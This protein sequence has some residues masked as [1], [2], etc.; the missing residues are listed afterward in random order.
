[1]KSGATS[2]LALIRLLDDYR[3]YH[4]ML[5]VVGGFFLLILLVLILV[6]RRK[7]K[8][9]SRQENR[10]WTFQRKM[11]FSFGVLSVVV[12]LLL[13]VIVAANVGTVLRPRPGFVGTIEMLG[14]PSAGTQRAKL[15]EAF[16]R[17]L[18]SGRATMPPAIRAAIDDR[19]A[20][21]RPKAIIS[22]ILLAL[23]AV[24]SSCIWRTLLRRSLVGRA[25]PMEKSRALRLGGVTSVAL[26]LVLML[27]VMGNTQGAIAPLCDDT[28]LR[29]AV[30]PVYTGVR[31]IF[32]TVKIT[33]WA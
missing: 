19:L 3:E 24:L 14:T 27:M 22:S 11:Y 21:Q 20:W 29:V 33:S 18:H 13:A 12:G 17:W 15:D 5:V 30:F 26:C 7:V 16:T 25:A 32:T 28:R 23:C 2:N 1:M 8:E 9:S 10:G 31:V 6:F 4:V